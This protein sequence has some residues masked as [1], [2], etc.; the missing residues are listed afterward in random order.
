MEVHEQAND[1]LSGE[2]DLLDFIKTSRILRFI[3][4]YS[5]RR[6]QRQ[7]VQYFNAYHLDENFLQLPQEKPPQST[8]EMLEKFDPKKNKNDHRILFEII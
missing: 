6:K 4:S 3:T 5:L 7:L 8:F 1:R 2:I